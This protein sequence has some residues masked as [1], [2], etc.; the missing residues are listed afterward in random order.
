ML[1][2]YDSTQP[3]RAAVDALSG[4]TVLEFDQLEFPT[5]GP[6]ALQ[7][8]SDGRWTQYKQIKVRR[9]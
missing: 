7:A 2:P 1:A 8:H 4:D 5:P 6:I 9:I 3:D